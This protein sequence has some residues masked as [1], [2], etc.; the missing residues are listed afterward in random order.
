MRWISSTTNVPCRPG[1]GLPRSL[2]WQLVGQLLFLGPSG[3][4]AQNNSREQH[5]QVG[6]APLR[7]PSP[8]VLWSRLPHPV[9]HPATQPAPRQPN[10]WVP[11]IPYPNT[12]TTRAPGC[13]STNATERPW[14]GMCVLGEGTGT[15]ALPGGYPKPLLLCISPMDATR[16]PRWGR[17][18]FQAVF[19]SWRAERGGATYK[20]LRIID[21]K[22]TACPPTHPQAQCLVLPLKG[23]GRQ[24]LAPKGRVGSSSLPGSGSPAAQLGSLWTAQRRLQRAAAPLQRWVLCTGCDANS[25]KAS[26]AA[27]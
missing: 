8:C 25:E 15:A 24:D 22:L 19:S 10:P 9:L 21:V 7:S 27:H 14:M 3:L 12:S 26:E 13:D 11:G 5:E 6:V 20:L 17:G 18:T 1:D 16:L 2:L 4:F 23:G